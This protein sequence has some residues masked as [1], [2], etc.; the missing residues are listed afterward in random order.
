[1]SLEEITSRLTESVGSDCGIPKIVKFD[2][3]EDGVV[4]IDGKSTP[5]KV[6]NDDLDADC[7]VKVAMSDFLE[8]ASGS[9]NPQMA[10]M[11]GKLKVEGDMSVAMQLGKL[12]G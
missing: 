6:S 2:F 4:S 9:L 7:T 11:T 12:V 5:N 10:F 8:M 1:M 3:G